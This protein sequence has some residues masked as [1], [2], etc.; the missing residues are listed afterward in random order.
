MKAEPE[1]ESGFAKAAQGMRGKPGRF[2]RFRWVL[3]AL[4]LFTGAFLF[5]KYRVVD[6]QLRPIIEKQL[7]QA[8]H[9]PVSIGSVRA[10]LTGNVVLNHVMLTMPGSP[11]ESHLS[12]EQISVSVDL[13]SLLFHRKP[14]ENCIESLAFVRPQIILAKNEIIPTV[15][16]APVSGN[17]ASPVVSTLGPPIPV[18]P[19]PRIS[20]RDGSFSIQVE[21]TPREVLRGLNF[22]AFTP[23][24]A[25]WGLSLPGPVP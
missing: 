16:S 22:N 25:I 13:V 14:P 7:A 9:S 10:G 11:W 2:R 24:G 15:A 20:I 12:V 21:K 23:D 6:T 3:A 1:A 4:G 19:V 17:P 8:V 18:F 5:F